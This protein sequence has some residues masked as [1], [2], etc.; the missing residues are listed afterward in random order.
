[1]RLA[2]RLIS[3]QIREKIS[4]SPDYS[5]SEVVLPS[6]FYGKTISS[7]QLKS[8][9]SINLIFIKRIIHDID[10][11][12]NPENDINIIE[13]EDSTE[14]KENDILILTGRNNKIDDFIKAS[15]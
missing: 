12:G 4:F 14:L 9:F 10:E 2:K 15:E 11:L 7:L 8:K 6:G 3:P 13:P 1:M 5:L